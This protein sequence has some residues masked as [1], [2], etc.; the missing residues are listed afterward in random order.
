[1]KKLTIV[2]LLTDEMQSKMPDT[3]E[4]TEDWGP[5][6]IVDNLGFPI[7]TGKHC[8]IE[9]TQEIFDKWYQSCD[10]FVIGHGIPQFQEFDVHKNKKDQNE[11]S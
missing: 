10:M 7:T 5:V 9:C 3:V 4:I 6:T 8:I 11:K 2:I 1:M